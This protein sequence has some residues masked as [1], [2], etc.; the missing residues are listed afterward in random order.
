MDQGNFLKVVD[1]LEKYQQRVVNTKS[2][3]G[4][5]FILFK[6]QL[7]QMYE[8]QNRSID[9]HDT[10]SLTLE[11]NNL[12]WL[13]QANLDYIGE[14]EKV[15]NLDNL[16]SHGQLKGAIFK[17]KALSATRLRGLG[18]FALAG[19]IYA[20]LTA[21]SM[22]VGPTIP[23]LGMVAASVYGMTSFNE[24]GTISKIEYVNEGEHVGMLR[25]T[26]QKSP[27]VSYSIVCNPKHTMS[28]CAVGNDDA[29]AEDAEGNILMVREYL[30]ESSGQPVAG[31][32]FTVPA[33]AHR[34]KATMEWIFSEKSPNS[35]TDAAYNDII[36]QRHLNLAKTG[37][38]SGLR[39]L[40]VAQT[41]Y[42]NFGDEEEINMQLSHE[43]DATDETLVAMTNV[44]GQKNLEQMKPAEFY[45]LYKEYSL[46]KN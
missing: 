31:G 34:D 24:K 20:K 41:G 6:R 1:T 36:I 28:I 29:G 14:M 45:R 30:D 38:I 40:T 4:K 37:G 33:D 16:V 10:F 43:D 13:Y 7:Y 21:L 12:S 8:V 17:Q 39:A 18:A 44:Y 25:L 3:S 11:R 19:G 5:E 15:Q 32:F 27:F 23:M 26:V 46:G 22:M 2:E 35:T 9:E 42:A